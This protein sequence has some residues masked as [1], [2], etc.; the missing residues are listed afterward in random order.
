MPLGSTIGPARVIGIEDPES[1]KP[2]ELMK[3]GVLKGERLLFRTANSSRC[4]KT[5]EFVRDFVYI[6]I[7]AAVYL[8]EKGIRAVGIDYLSVGG[9]EKNGAQTHITL[10]K[11]GIWIIEG[12]DLR[13]V[14][15]GEYELIC[16]P[17]KILDSDGAPAR[18]VIRRL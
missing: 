10:M 3:H 2:G 6:S 11:A 16:L 1:V 18:A 17:L 14:A 5:D 15:E 4:W 12:L 8:V 9:F 13:N 7:E